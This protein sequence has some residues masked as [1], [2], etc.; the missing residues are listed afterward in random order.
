M[1]EY[2]LMIKTFGEVQ[3]GPDYREIISEVQRRLPEAVFIVTGTH[4]R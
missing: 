4:K 3:C 2:E 1:S